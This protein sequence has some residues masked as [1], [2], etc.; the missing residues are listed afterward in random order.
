MRRFVKTIAAMQAAVLLLTNTAF[1]DELFEEAPVSMDA[2][3]EADMSFD[4]ETA[5]SADVENVDAEGAEAEDVND[6]SEDEMFDAFNESGEDAVEEEEFVEPEAEDVLWESLGDAGQDLIEGDD[7]MDEMEFE[8]LVMLGAN[9]P[10]EWKEIHKYY[11]SVYDGMLDAL[12]IA[13]PEIK[14]LVPLLKLL[15]G[16]TLFKEGPAQDNTGEI[17]KE[18]L[19]DISTQIKTLEQTL[20]DHTYNVVSL[21]QIGDKYSTVKDKALTVNTHISD[22]MDDNTISYDEQRKEIADI[23]KSAEFD[24][25][26]SAMNGAT[27]CFYSSENNIFEKRT[28]LMPLMTGPVRRSCSAARRSTFHFPTS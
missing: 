10:S 26:I 6:G 21:A 1:A 14:P 25:L 11:K 2:G 15:L 19:N 13:A 20:K 16:N 17:I 7:F 22:I 18:K 23:Y 3:I 5:G 9:A 27:D 12:A 28:S 8:E 4:N 24:S